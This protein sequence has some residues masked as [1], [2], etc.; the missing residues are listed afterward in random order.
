[1]CEHKGVEIIEANAGPTTSIKKL[2]SIP[3]NYSVPQK[4][5]YLK[6]KDSLMIFECR[7]NTKWIWLLVVGI[8]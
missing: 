7:A 6:G 4:M 3:P 5:G 8:S 2:V 1:M